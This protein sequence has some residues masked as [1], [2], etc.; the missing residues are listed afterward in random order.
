MN[1]TSSHEFIRKCPKC[2]KI[3]SRLYTDLYPKGNYCP[4]AMMCCGQEI[5]Y[6]PNWTPVQPP[7]GP[8]K[9]YPKENPIANNA[10]N[11]MGFI[12]EAESI[13]RFSKNRPIWQENLIY[14]AGVVTTLSIYLLNK[15]T[16][17]YGEEVFSSQL[18]CELMARAVVH[19]MGEIV[20][21]DVVRPT[22][23][24]TDK[25]ATAFAQLEEEGVKA[26]IKKYNL[27][28][29]WEIDWQKG[30]NDDVGIILKVADVTAV[31]VTCR[32]ELWLFSNRSFLST[33]KECQAYISKT[34]NELVYKGDHAGEDKKAHFVCD[35]LVTFLLELNTILSQIVDHYTNGEK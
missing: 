3:T 9:Y 25:L 1:M 24:A 27:P 11:I 23:Y 35:F 31:A 19:D 10:K 26:V 18:A 21:G 12:Q 17:E 5:P 8:Q 28:A 15:M 32:R 14:H 30:K 22:K 6:D 33:T 16:E 20:T 29:I 4:E 2:G 7:D 13:Q 34:I